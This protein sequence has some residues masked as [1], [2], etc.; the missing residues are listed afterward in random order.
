MPLQLD[1]G[2]HF[3]GSLPRGC[4]RRTTRQI[5]SAS[6]RQ[7]LASYQSGTVDP[8]RTKVLMRWYLTSALSCVHG[9]RCGLR[10]KPGQSRLSEE[11]ARFLD[12]FILEYRSV[13]VAG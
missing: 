9:K 8:S 1:T 2:T 11:R 3:T 10:D 12:A 4:Q 7:A 5:M 6:S 13:S